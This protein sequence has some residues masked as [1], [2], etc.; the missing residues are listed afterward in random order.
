MVPMQQ[1]GILKILEGLT[2]VEE[3]E[4]ITGPLGE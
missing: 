2:T 4:R 1:D 3:L